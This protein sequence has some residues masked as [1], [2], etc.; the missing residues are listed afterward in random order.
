MLQLILLLGL[1]AGISGCAAIARRP[2]TNRKCVASLMVVLGAWVVS[3]A[4]TW[5]F[6]T[7]S[8]LESLALVIGVLPVALLVCASLLAV[9]GLKEC[10]RAKGYFMQGPG[11]AIATLCLSGLLFAL[12]GFV[13]L[14][15]MSSGFLGDNR[16]LGGQPVVFEQ[17]NF[18]FLVPT[19]RWAQVNTNSLEPGATAAFHC[20][21]PELHFLIIAQ[22]TPGTNFSL[23][24]LADL[25][26]RNYSNTVAKA[27]VTYRGATQLERLDGERLHGEG[28]ESGR[29]M[30]Y[31]YRLFLAAGLGYQ[32]ILWG[33]NRQAVG[34]EADY[35]AARFQ[36]LDLNR[37]SLK[38]TNSP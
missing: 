24:D 23:Q 34:E 14:G 25:A 4:L 7:V 20:S 30:Y 16:P 27:R 15:G 5:L 9:G 8:G 36:I 21:R 32:L 17:F 26:M 33:P 22:P 13:A 18:K 28:E 11:Q 3:I 2:T 19:K 1:L 12:I 6:N 38:G 29:K 35:L 37:G 31:Q 10:A